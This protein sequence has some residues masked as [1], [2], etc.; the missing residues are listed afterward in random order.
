ML[1]LLSFC[2]FCF[3]SL[4]FLSISLELFL[5]VPLLFFCPADHVPDWQPRKLLGMVE[6]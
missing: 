3:V 2:R 5:D 4:C 6:A 1:V